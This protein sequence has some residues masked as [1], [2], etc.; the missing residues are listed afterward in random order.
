MSRLPS[1]FHFVLCVIANMVA[2]YSSGKTGEV[3]VY[4]R[5]SSY[6]NLADSSLDGV[7]N[8][9]KTILGVLFKWKF[10]HF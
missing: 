10:M 6:D 1:E 4:C 2:R 5:S 3:S 7:C 9:E 8:L